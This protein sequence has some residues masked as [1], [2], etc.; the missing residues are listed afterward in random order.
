MAQD[1][2]LLVLV[3]PLNQFARKHGFTRAGR[4]FQNKATVLLKDRRKAIDDFLLPIS[5]LH[6]RHISKIR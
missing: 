4:R 2:N 3:E 5:K 6:G 1:N